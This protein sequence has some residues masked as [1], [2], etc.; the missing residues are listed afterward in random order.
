VTN[1]DLRDALHQMLTAADG[2]VLA[3]LKRDGR[4]QLINVNHHYA[5]AE[6][7][8]RFSISDGDAKTHNLRRD[9]RA[10]YHVTNQDRSAYTV[11]EGAAALTAAAT[12]PHDPVVDEHISLYRAM[13]GEHPD[14]DK[15][16]QFVVSNRQLV[17]SL[18]VE[19][20]YGIP[21]E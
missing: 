8:I 12:G 13:D 4:P 21:Q 3:P 14:W 1:N 17:L 5:P 18:T 20:L 7:V 9:P 15:F 19:R 2:G 11:A 16:R 10:S 6:R